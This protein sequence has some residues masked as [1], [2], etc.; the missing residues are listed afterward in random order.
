MNIFKKIKRIMKTFLN[1]K[2]Y[3]VLLLTNKNK[4]RTQRHLFIYYLQHRFD[5]QPNKLNPQIKLPQWL[6]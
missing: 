2:N 1:L 3:T 4:K 6:L 5:T